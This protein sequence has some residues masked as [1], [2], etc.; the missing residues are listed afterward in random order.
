M[1]ET[2][3]RLTSHSNGALRV[4]SKSL[5]PKKRF[6]SGEAKRPKLR[7]WQS[8]QAWTRMPLVGVEAR[9]SAISAADPRRNGNGPASMR[10]YRIGISSGTRPAFVS[11]SISTG[12]RRS[13][14]GVHPAWDFR[15]A[16]VLRLLPSLMRAARET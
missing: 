14:G 11:S 12:S 5:I 8:P 3:S 6:R 1:N 10:P 2:A 15:E 16:F 7:R 13:G 9:S 4:S